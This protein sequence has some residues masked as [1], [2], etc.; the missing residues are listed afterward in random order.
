MSRRVA[1]KKKVGQDA[2][3]TYVWMI[4]VNVSTELLTSFAH[5]I[6][7][8]Q[9][10]HAAEYD[11][12]IRMG[13]LW[14][15]P[16]IA[17]DRWTSALTEFFDAIQAD[18]MARGI[19]WNVAGMR[20][21]TVTTTA[22]SIYLTT[23]SLIRITAKEGEEVRL[24]GWCL[25]DAPGDDETPVELPARFRREL[26]AAVR[27]HAV[28][29]AIRYRQ[30][31]RAAAGTAK[32]SAAATGSPKQKGKGT[33][34]YWRGR[35][36]KELI[37]AMEAAGVTPHTLAQEMKNREMKIKSSTIKAW[38]EF[39]TNPQDLDRCLRVCKELRS[40]MPKYT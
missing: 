24:P 25:R 32:R 36:Q 30:T 12:S 20:A 8:S 18:C 27:R 2:V 21:H 29:S 19:E 22:V 14:F 33:S 40:R 3:S 31:E 10:F 23:P 4:G 17:I 16:A 38:I 26:V 28:E 13:G 9:G 39:R 35:I 15:D 34:L 5:M 37:P 11:L 1:S 6:R 7:E